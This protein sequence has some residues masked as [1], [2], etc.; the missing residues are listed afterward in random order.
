MSRAIGDLAPARLRFSQSA[1]G[2]GAN[3]RRGRDGPETRSR[4]TV[5]DQDVPCLEIYCEQLQRLRGLVFGCACHPTCTDDSTLHGDFPGWAQ[6]YL[7]QEHPTC[8]AIFVQ[9]CAADTNPMPR[10]TSDPS[11]RGD[12]A[13]TYG[14]ILSYAV[15]DARA[16]GGGH[17]SEL[18]GPIVSRYGEVQLAFDPARM[19]SQAELEAGAA[20]GTDRPARAAAYQLDQ[21]QRHGTL[22]EFAPFPAQLWRIGG[23]GGGSGLSIFALTGECVADYSLAIK[24]RH[25][26]GSTWVSACASPSDGAASLSKR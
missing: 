15:E 8:T 10:Q 5:V 20:A 2:L 21:L 14:Q 6:H 18:V 12:L 3:R 1:A 26:W 7:E 9:G 4:P 16:A 19:P 25:G 11:R 23:G 24:A 17:S 22:E 13:A